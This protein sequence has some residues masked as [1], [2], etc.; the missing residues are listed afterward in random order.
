[1]VWNQVLDWRGR[2][3]LVDGLATSYAETDR[4]LSELKKRPELAFLNEVS[5][6]PLQQTLRHQS[7]AFNNFFAHRARYPRFKSRRGRKTATYTRSAF[8]Y[9]NGQLF[10]AKQTGPL[11]FVW[12]WTEIDPGTIIPSTVTVTHDADGRWYV[13]FQ[14]DI[15][16]PQPMPKTGN[17]VGVD[18]GITSFA[19]TSDGEL[20]EPPPA[21]TQAT[22]PG[23][24]SAPHGP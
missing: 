18:V 24:I 13:T 1:M 14:L 9:R 5:S 6:V 2:R 15:A 21:A 12:S 4:F 23:P 7:R 8:R 11:R 17:A 22:Q 20:I 16:D 3:Y 10:L 19:A